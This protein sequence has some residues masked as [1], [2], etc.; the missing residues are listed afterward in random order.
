V[1]IIFLF[2]EGESSSSSSNGTVRLVKA[3]TMTKVHGL[4][5][6]YVQGCGVPR[7]GR[8]ATGARVT[9]CG[10]GLDVR[11]ISSVILYRGT[12]ARVVTYTVVNLDH[13][14]LL[15]PAACTGAARSRYVAF[16]S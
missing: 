14:L 15:D 7:P 12:G 2:R 10:M 4:P 9:M 13:L 3:G 8:C 16:S 5:V 11:P 1:G 6:R